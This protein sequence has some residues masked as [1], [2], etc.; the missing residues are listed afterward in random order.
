[1]YAATLEGSMTAAH[2]RQQMPDF[3]PPAEVG[4][5]MV[6]N[7]KP[8]SSE[9]YA[10]SSWIA[11]ELRRMPKQIEQIPWW[12]INRRRVARKKCDKFSTAHEVIH[13]YVYPEEP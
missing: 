9:C 6:G 8:S 2:D 4:P 1:V 7:P 11:T 12:Q 5:P 3:E 13:Y 10:V